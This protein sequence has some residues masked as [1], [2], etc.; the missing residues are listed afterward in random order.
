MILQVIFGGIVVDVTNE[1]SGCHRL[2]FYCRDAAR[3]RG[4]GINQGAGNDTE[5]GQ[6]TYF[7]LR[8]RVRAYIIPSRE[9]RQA[10]C[11][12]TNGLESPQPER[13]CRITAKTRAFAPRMAPQFQ[14]SRA[15]PPSPGD[16]ALPTPATHRVLAFSFPRKEAKPGHYG[17][18]R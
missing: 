3:A 13:R 16:E 12:E 14:P 1:Q 7:A 2:C 17:A 18:P 6:T 11:G 9:K 4:R 15:A 5:C 8:L 10:N